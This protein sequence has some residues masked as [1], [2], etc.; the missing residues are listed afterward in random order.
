MQILVALLDFLNIAR[1]FHQFVL[2]FL[3]HQMLDLGK[4]HLEETDQL[5][6]EHGGAG[7][8]SRT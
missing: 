5:F 6:Q 4:Y 7:P 3:R 2:F 1:Y 8:F